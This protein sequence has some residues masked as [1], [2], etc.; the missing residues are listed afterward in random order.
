MLRKNILFT[1]VKTNN[2]IIRVSI[3]DGEYI[4]YS[5]NLDEG[6]DIMIKSWNVGESKIYITGES[7]GEPANYAIDIDG[8]SPAQQIGEGYV[9]T[10]IGSLK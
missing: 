1:D 9:F 4:K 7:N 10:C 6:Q 8:N 2:E 5:A 3:P